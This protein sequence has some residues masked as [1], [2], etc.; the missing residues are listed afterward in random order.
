[1]DQRDAAETGRRLSD[2]FL[3]H[4]KYIEIEYTA[5]HETDEI[6]R[7]TNNTQQSNYA[8]RWLAIKQANAEP[9]GLYNMWTSGIITD[10]TLTLFHIYVNILHCSFRIST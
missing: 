5:N 3:L 4:G 6:E 10:Y 2:P 7:Q 1:L 9:D 8:V